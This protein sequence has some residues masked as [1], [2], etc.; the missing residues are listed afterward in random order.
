MV[1]AVLDLVV[2][3]F[4]LHL[5]VLHLHLLD[6]VVV[7]LIFLMLSFDYF[8]R[9]C[10]FGL[11]ASITL[12]LSVMLKSISSNCVEAVLVSGLAGID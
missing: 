11:R 8:A 5:F 3:D 2:F 12:E 9:L 1:F 7:H 4:Y 6:L 10:C